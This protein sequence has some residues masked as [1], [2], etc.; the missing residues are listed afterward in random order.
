METLPRCRS[1]DINV[2]I[3]KYLDDGGIRKVEVKI[4]WN[5]VIEYAHVTLSSAG[6]IV[7]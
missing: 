7:N 3:L 6:L 5:E 1:F 4:G 2:D